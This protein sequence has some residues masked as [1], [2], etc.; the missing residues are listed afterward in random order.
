[1]SNFKND[2]SVQYGSQVLVIGSAA[3]G[4]GGS[5]YVADNIEIS[6]PSKTIERTNHLDEPSGQVSYATFVTGSATVQLADDSAVVPK[7]GW[8]FTATFDSEF[9]AEVFYVD[10]ISQPFS[11]DAETKVNITFRKKI[12]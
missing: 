6:R 8:E 3:G 7:H 11:K 1:M 12:N 9:G 4:V 10:S 5:N 2:G